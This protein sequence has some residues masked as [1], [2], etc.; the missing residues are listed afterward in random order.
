[1]TLPIRSVE[2]RP[3]RFPLRRPIRSALG[4][5]GHVESVLV[6]VHTDGPSGTGFAMGLGGTWGRAVAAY[7]V[8]E[9]TPLAVDQDALEPEA[10]W[11]RLWSP[12]KAR[13][14]AG[15]G[16]WALSAI[17]IAIW[18]VRAQHHGETLHT[19]LGGA[20]GRVPVYG[21]GGWHDLDDAELVAECESFANQGVR[22]YK[23][24][25]GSPRDLERTRVLR[26][27]M[28]DDFT[29]LADANQGLTVE[30]AIE[31]SAMLHDFGVGWIEEPVVAD[32]I[33]DL[34]RVAA[35]SSV[36]V[37]VGENLYFEWG[38]RDVCARRAAAYLQPD[39]AR[40][41]GVTEFRKIAALAERN[42]LHLSSHLWHELSV[43][44]VGASPAGWAVEYADLLPPGTFTRDFPIVD[45][46][47]EIPAE[48]GHGLMFSPPVWGR[49]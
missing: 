35:S 49:S 17:D 18:D 15:L 32:S 45:G 21:S 41:G 10:L 39:V 38:F 30:G 31:L 4:S 27:A 6:A 48:G 11:H 9:L 2:V 14:R 43:S 28:G 22:A 33:E 24:K 46:H 5:Y 8:D 12:N 7:L 13:M 36:P 29:L 26:S 34:A 44:L 19:M 3:Q 37:A 20:G 42:G 1:M 16:V 23:Y 47:L 40:C 25:V